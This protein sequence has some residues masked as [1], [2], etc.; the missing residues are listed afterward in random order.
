[1]ADIIPEVGSLWR[2]RPEVC[3][4]DREHI[5]RVRELNPSWP[6]SAGSVIYATEPVGIRISAPASKFVEEFERVASSAS[7][8]G[9]DGERG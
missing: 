7:H 6:T 5:V 8:A 9:K 3:D 1:V 2:H 4:L